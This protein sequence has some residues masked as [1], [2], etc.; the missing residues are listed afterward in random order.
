MGA[1][2][3]CLRSRLELTDDY[4]AGYKQRLSFWLNL[5]YAIR[6]LLGNKLMSNFGPRNMPPWSVFNLALTSTLVESSA[7]PPTSTT[8]V[9]AYFLFGQPALYIVDMTPSTT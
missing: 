1:F 4:G 5:I 6:T 7:T 3:R 8:P 9:I 2:G